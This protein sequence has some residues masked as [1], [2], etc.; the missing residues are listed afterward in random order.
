MCSDQ[1]FWL[2]PDKSHWTDPVSVSQVKL[3]GQM[4]SFFVWAV[5][6]LRIKSDRIHFNISF[7]Y[8]YGYT[9]MYEFIWINSRDFYKL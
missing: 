5:Y 1:T 4:S 7:S 3:L 2:P 9:Y 6:I 8:V